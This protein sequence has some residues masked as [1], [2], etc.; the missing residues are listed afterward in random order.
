[1]TA[2]SMCWRYLFVGIVL[3]ARLKTWPVGIDYCSVYD[4]FHGNVSKYEADLRNYLD[5]NLRA[6]KCVIAINIV[7]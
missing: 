5:S 2:M 4:C 7:L 1:M 3:M 6:E